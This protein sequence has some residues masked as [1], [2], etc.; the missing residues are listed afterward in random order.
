[1]FGPISLNAESMT[2]GWQPVLEL[3]SS[4]H[5]HRRPRRDI[6]AIISRLSGFRSGIFAQDAER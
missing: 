4:G 5:L 2:I 1:M 3:I 6:A